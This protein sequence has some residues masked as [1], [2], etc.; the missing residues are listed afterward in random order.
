MES[1]VV[2]EMPNEQ[3]TY[4][5]LKLIAQSSIG[6]DLFKLQ[7]KHKISIYTNEAADVCVPGSRRI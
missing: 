4:G 3:S 2:L 5:F 7:C 6:Q 1:I